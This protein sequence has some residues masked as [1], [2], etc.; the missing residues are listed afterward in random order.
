MSVS[1]ASGLYVV[2]CLLPPHPGAAAAAVTMNVDFGPLILF[3]IIVAAP[4]MLLGHWW[5]V[6]MGKKVVPEAV[7]EEDEIPEDLSLRPSAF[8][9]FL[10]VL[11]PI[12]LI[13]A[14]SIFMNV[15]LASELWFK[16]LLALGD[17][18][19]ALAIGVLF[20]LN[21]KRN[22]DKK[23][24]SM[25]LNEALEKA[26]GI[27]VIT[28]A[29]GAFGAILA[30]TNI[31]QH[32]AQLPILGSIG[33]LFPFLLAFVL[34]TAQGSSTVAII[35]AA[36]IVLPLLPILGLDSDNGRIICVLTLGAGSMMISHANDSYFWVIAKFSG[37]DMKAMLK[38]YS[39]VTIL[40]G[41]TSFIFIWL[42]SK[43]IL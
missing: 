39:T 14:R 26:S 8:K 33:L 17:P 40:M 16:N 3:G 13:A 15:S 38:A 32:F 34:K 42:L 1:L 11:L 12:V 28:G 41:I 21:A 25:L 30:A 18:V 31:G 29:G 36:S 2:H 35:T 24:L 20:A 5:A 9:A 6:Y 23:T 7:T 43:I 27:L 10:P 37:I 19:I 4:V 22:W